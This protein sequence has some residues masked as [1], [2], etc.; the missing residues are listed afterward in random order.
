[1][2]RFEAEHQELIRLEEA[3]YNE[4]QTAF[5][6][7]VWAPGSSAQRPEPARPEPP[8]PTGAPPRRRRWAR[9]LAVAL[10]AF[11]LG[12]LVAAAAL[13]APGRPPASPDERSA[14]AG[15][16]TAPRPQPREHVPA[17]TPRP[18]TGPDARPRD[19][20]SGA[21]SDAPRQVGVGGSARRPFPTDPR[22]RPRAQAPAPGSRASPRQRPGG[23][24]RQRASSSERRSPDRRPREATPVRGDPSARGAPQRPARRT[25]TRAESGAEGTSRLADT[26]RASRGSDERAARGGAGTRTESPES[27]ERAAPGCQGRD[28]DAC[29]RWL[30]SQIQ[31][32]PD[33]VRGGLR[34]Q[35]Q[36]LMGMKNRISP[37]RFFER[38][39]ALA[40]HSRRLRRP[41]EALG[42][43]PGPRP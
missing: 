20:A 11:G 25:G 10:P 5:P 3:A 40:R 23:A 18:A 24:G 33:D 39:E 17:A 12:T 6:T 8:R 22:P 43:G 21:R 26:R 41:E 9:D 7:A 13:W 36:A 31:K 16:A 35:L 2:D 15:L 34:A 29:L 32:V 28:Q 38:A 37:Q 4:E 30:A 14:R 42:S 27:D 19:A 1:V